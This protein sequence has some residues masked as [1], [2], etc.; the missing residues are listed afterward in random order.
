[1]KDEASWREK[2]N[3]IGFALRRVGF[4]YQAAAA[5]SWLRRET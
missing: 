4:M 1:M 3:E 5:T 2:P